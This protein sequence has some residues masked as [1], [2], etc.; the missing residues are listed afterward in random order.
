LDY[1]GGL[2]KTL[3]LYPLE[4]EASLKKLSQ[5]GKDFGFSSIPVR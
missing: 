1:L 4:L 2:S 3:S 5:E